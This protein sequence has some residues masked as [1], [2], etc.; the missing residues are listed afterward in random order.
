VQPISSRL[1]GEERHRRAFSLCRRCCI[2]R[3]IF[4]FILRAPKEVLK[5]LKILFSLSCLFC[6]SFKGDEILSGDVSFEYQSSE[7]AGESK[8][9]DLFLY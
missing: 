3:T 2:D 9:L 1:G 5:N 7:K 4:R 6:S 8:C